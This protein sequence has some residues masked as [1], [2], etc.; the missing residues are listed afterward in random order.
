MFNKGNV[1]PAF[2]DI[3]VVKEDLNTPSTEVVEDHKDYKEYESEEKLNNDWIKSITAE[4]EN[5]SRGLLTHD[6]NI[7]ELKAAF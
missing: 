2:V 3:N 6:L 5:M 7:A 1:L 4:N